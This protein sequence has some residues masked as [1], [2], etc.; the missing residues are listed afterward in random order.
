MDD[1]SS[2]RLVTNTTETTRAR[3][4]LVSA[5]SNQRLSLCLLR[6]ACHVLAKV[7]NFI[8]DSLDDLVL[9][10]KRRS[11]GTWRLRTWVNYYL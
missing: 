5:S 10:K 7:V 2:V 3:K 1:W 9:A 6:A 8:G 11:R 4:R